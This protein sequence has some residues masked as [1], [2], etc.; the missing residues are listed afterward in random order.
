MNEITPRE[1]EW[2]VNG[3]ANGNSLVGQIIVQDDHQVI[4]K[5]PLYKP[6]K[7]PVEVV[8]ISKDLHLNGRIIDTS[9]ICLIEVFGENSIRLDPDSARLLIWTELP[10]K[11]LRDSSGQS[12]DASGLYGR[13]G[14]LKHP[15]W[16]VNGIVNGNYSVGVLTTDQQHSAT[17]LSP[18]V[19]PAKNPVE[20]IAT[21]KDVYLNGQYADRKVVSHIQVVEGE[22]TLNMNP[23]FARLLVNDTLAL[24]L[25]VQY[26]NMA[27]DVVGAQQPVYGWGWY[28][29][30]ITPKAPETTVNGIA[31]GSINNACTSPT[32]KI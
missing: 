6:G 5:A 3:I 21:Y 11:I 8:A 32:N 17:F 18:A 27:P 22:W 13:D 29:G 2:T 19:K 20:I 10:L 16:M 26:K 24:S 30:S 12:F 7:N 14:T 9:I 28:Y 1:P 4:F 23:D 15:E 31:N 25:F